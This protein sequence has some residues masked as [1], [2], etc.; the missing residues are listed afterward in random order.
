MDQLCLRLVGRYFG[1]RHCYELTYTKC[2]EHDP[3][4]SALLRNP[5]AL[6]AI[7]ANVE[8]ASVTELILALKV[9]SW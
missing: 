1:C 4:V 7:L 5:E 3:R 2:Q 9:L 8:A 6:A